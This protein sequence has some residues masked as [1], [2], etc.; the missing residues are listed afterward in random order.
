MKILKFN[1]FI[2]EKILLKDANEVLNLIKKNIS[3]KA[4]LIGGF[5]KGKLESEHDIDILIPDKKFNKKLKDKIFN[6]LNAKS[7]EDTDWGGWYFSTDWGDVDIFYTT[8]DFDY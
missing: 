5:G 1:S 4:E 6:L 2:N 3:N 8:K 7:V